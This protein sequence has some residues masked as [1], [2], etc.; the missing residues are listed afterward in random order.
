M[1][2]YFDSHYSDT[3]DIIIRA[4]KNEKID[5]LHCFVALVD[6]E[7][8]ATD[9][10]EDNPMMVPI[11]GGNDYGFYQFLASNGYI[12]QIDHIDI[13]CLKRNGFMYFT[14]WCSKEEWDED[15]NW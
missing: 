15:T 5:L 1:F 14:P 10:D 9:I 6:S 11:M 7:I 8:E 2:A 12:Y 3:P 4:D 13:D